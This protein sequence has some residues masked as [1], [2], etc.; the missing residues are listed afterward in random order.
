MR[1]IARGSGIPCRSFRPPT[2]HIAGDT[3]NGGGRVALPI[4]L[5]PTPYVC[6]GGGG[7]MSCLPTEGSWAEWYTVPK[8]WAPSPSARSDL[9]RKY[10]RA[11]SGNTD[12]GSAAVIRQSCSARCGVTVTVRTRNVSMSNRLYEAPAHG[13]ANTPGSCP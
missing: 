10:L 2:R 8:M 4:Y 13:N 6:G 1:I 7:G 5:F 11:R 3:R 9:Y 12:V